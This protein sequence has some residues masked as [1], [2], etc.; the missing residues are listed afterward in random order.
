MAFAINAF[1]IYLGMERDF[2]LDC[3]PYLKYILVSQLN[4]TLFIE[5]KT[6]SPFH[7][8]VT[9]SL[10]CCYV[11]LEKKKKNLENCQS[12]LRRGPFLNNVSIL[13][14]NEYGFLCCYCCCCCCCRSLCLSGGG[15][16]HYKMCRRR[17]RRDRMSE[18]GREWLYGVR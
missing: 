9:P 12:L 6:D 11:T 7:Q 1:V 4:M 17:E 16:N 8:V 2:L 3:A 10:L 15:E 18:R 5:F 14:S 13:L